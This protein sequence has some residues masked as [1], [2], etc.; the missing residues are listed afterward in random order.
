[1]VL[2]AVGVPCGATGA[3]RA[4]G[5]VVG[6]ASGWVG[7]GGSIACL[8]RTMSDLAR[9]IAASRRRE[10]DAVYAALLRRPGDD[11]DIAGLRA[12]VQQVLGGIEQRDFDVVAPF[13]AGG[14][15]GVDDAGFELDGD[16]GV[17]ALA[18]GLDR[19]AFDALE[20]AT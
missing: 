5:W 3:A 4:S 6:G 19:A 17:L 8:R 13:A 1:M 14:D 20:D 18:D 7:G 10:R 2:G 16:D 15:D 12:A 11:H 9:C